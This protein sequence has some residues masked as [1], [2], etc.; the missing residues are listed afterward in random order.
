MILVKL[1]ES[2]RS[3]HDALES[4]VDVMN[5]MFTL[6]DYG[7]LLGKFYR[8]YSVVEPKLPV[9]G[10]REAGFDAETRRKTP[11]LERDLGNLGTLDSIKSC[12]PWTNTPKTDS[13]AEAFGSVYVMEGATLGGQVIS[14]HL[15]QHLG[16][17]PDNGGAFFNSYGP[18][19]GKMWK[20]FGAIVTAWSE[21]HPEEDEAIVNSAMATFDCFRSCFEEPLAA[22]SVL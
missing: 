4:V 8:F 6:D 7:E 22:R 16:I 21:R 3:R 19:V 1:K 9:D 10:L 13:V 18:D 2:T 5:R 17:T 12:V 15:K 11:L 20:E 14:R